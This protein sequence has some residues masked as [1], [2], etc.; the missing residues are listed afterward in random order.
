M[1]SPNTVYSGQ[2]NARLS[3]F[4]PCPVHQSRSEQLKDKTKQ[5]ASTWQSGLCTKPF[6]YPLHHKIKYNVFEFTTVN[7]RKHQQ[8]FVQLSAAQF[9]W[10]LKRLRVVYACSRSDLHKLKQH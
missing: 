6:G 8:A 10:W 4:A 1:W 2:E 9:R 7:V 5:A 3:D